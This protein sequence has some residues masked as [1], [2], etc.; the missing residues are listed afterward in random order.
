MTN[1]WA[2]GYN[3][4]GS[5]RQMSVIWPEIN[6]EQ[7]LFTNCARKRAT[8]SRSMACH[9]ACELMKWQAINRQ[10][11]W[12]QCDRMYAY[13]FLV[14]SVTEA[15]VLR[16]V[17]SQ[18]KQMGARQRTDS[19]ASV[20]VA[21][22]IFSHT[23]FQGTLCS[24][25]PLLISSPLTWPAARGRRLMPQPRTV[26]SPSS[27]SCTHLDTSIS[28]ATT[29]TRAQA[30]VYMLIGLLSQLACSEIDTTNQSSSS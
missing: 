25:L 21:I 24:L 18:N 12:K 20:N 16:N 5:K 15:R 27:P 9:V 28:S 11:Q 30:V 3:Q 22:P 17:R 26:S 23:Y 6:T 19:L 29:D 13:S 7:H 4:T 1:Q 10:E 8:I 14:D 2:A